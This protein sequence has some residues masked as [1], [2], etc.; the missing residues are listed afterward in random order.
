MESHEK[1]HKIISEK[2]SDM[3]YKDK[4]NKL[5]SGMTRLQEYFRKHGIKEHKDNEIY[6][7]KKY[8]ATE[9]PLPWICE[10]YYGGATT[11]SLLVPKELALK[12]LTLGFLP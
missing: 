11:Y 7:Q 8:I 4:V 9:H 10:G 1:L 6:D 12:I 3:P 5:R 2:I